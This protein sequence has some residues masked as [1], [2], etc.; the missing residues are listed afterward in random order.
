MKHEKNSKDHFG[1]LSERLAM[2]NL[3]TWRDQIV[4]KEVPS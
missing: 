2:D 3:N 1:P 4:K